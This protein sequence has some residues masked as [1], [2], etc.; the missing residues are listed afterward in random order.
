MPLEYSTHLYSPMTPVGGAATHPTAGSPYSYV[1]GNTPRTLHTTSTVSSVPRTMP[2]YCAVARSSRLIRVVRDTATPALIHSLR[3]S[4]RRASR[5]PVRSGTTCAASSAPTL[6]E[7]S[8]HA[9]VAFVQRATVVR[10]LHS[11]R[12]PNRQGLLVVA[13]REDATRRQWPR[14][15]TGIQQQRVAPSQRRARSCRLARPIAFIGRN[16]AYRLKLPL[17]KPS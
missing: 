14:R 2:P 10:P 12:R 17:S 1:G 6:P 3:R 13:G 7:P 4:N 11:P 5:P 16:R 8:D 15:S 9:A